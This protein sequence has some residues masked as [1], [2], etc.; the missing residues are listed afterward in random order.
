MATM[1]TPTVRGE[2]D[3]A[4]AIVLQANE[5]FIGFVFYLKLNFVIIVMLQMNF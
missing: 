4:T 1:T 5:R 2:S 3:M